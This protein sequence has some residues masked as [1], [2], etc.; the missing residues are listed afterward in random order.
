M[1]PLRD[2]IAHRRFPI[3]TLGLILA[4]LAVFVFQM[5]LELSQRPWRGEILVHVGGILPGAV[6]D[7]HARDTAL[8]ELYDRARDEVNDRYAHRFLPFL[9]VDSAGRRAEIRELNHDFDWARTQLPFLGVLTLLTSLFLHG[10][11]AHLL[12]N[13][14]FLWIFGN[15]IEDRLGRFRFLLFYLLCGAAAG[16]VHVASGPQS[17]IPTI[18]ASGAIGGVLGA[19]VLLYPW[20][21]ILTLVLIFFIEVPA[22][23]FL[24]VWLLLQWLGAQEQMFFSQD[25]TMGGVAY[26]AHIGGFLAGFLFVRL[27]QPRRGYEGPLRVKIR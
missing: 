20:A 14:W 7:A 18:G 25:R 2:N 24:G 5:A 3:V 6:F 22:W 16:A 26:W 4:N 8:L 10:G 27:F 23:I 13:M 11:I 1:F 15:N 19:Y 21:R 9:T 12:G 17:L